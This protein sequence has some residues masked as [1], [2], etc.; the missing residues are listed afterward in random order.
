MTWGDE[1]DED[2]AELVAVIRYLLGLKPLPLEPRESTIRLDGE[3][4]LTVKQ[5]GA[6]LGLTKQGI[7]L[8]LQ[9]LQRDLAAG[10]ADA[11]ERATRPAM[12][13]NKRG[14]RRGRAAA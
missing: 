7:S 2:G 5:W 1:P 6:E 9:Q 8:R 14:K 3:R 13:Q 4:R 12:N 11:Y 10:R